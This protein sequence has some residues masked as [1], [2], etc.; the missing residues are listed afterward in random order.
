MPKILERTSTFCESFQH[1]KQTRVS[2]NS[3]ECSTSRPLEFVH[4]NICKPTRTLTLQGERYLFLFIDNYT[5]M[6]WVSIL[7]EKS[8]A[9]DKALFENENDLRIKFLRSYKRGEFT[10]ND[11]NEFYEK[12]GM[13][14]QLSIA[15]TP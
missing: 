15:T 13:E 2:F 8:E 11:F 1:G 6:V 10:S 4:T 7:K 5:K 12:Y 9:I 3:K 14:R